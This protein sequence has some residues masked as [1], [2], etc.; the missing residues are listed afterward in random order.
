MA[1]QLGNECRQA[2]EDGRFGTAWV[3]LLKCWRSVS[4]QEDLGTLF[5]PCAVIQNR[6]PER[7][8]PPADREPQEGLADVDHGRDFLDFRWRN[9]T[10]EAIASARDQHRVERV[11]L[12]RVVDWIVH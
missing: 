9:S 5:W 2:S 11:D 1:D 8:I 12:L 10:A 6:A 4:S 7:L 3:D